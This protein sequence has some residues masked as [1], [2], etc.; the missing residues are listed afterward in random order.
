MLLDYL[1]RV[2]HSAASGMAHPDSGHQEYRSCSSF[3]NSAARRKSSEVAST[4]VELFL[5]LFF[6]RFLV[7]T[8]TSFAYSLPHGDPYH[9]NCALKARP[10]FGVSG[11]AQCARRLPTVLHNCA[12]KIKSQFDIAWCMPCG[13]RHAS[14]QGSRG[15]ASRRA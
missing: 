13:M 6:L 2:G 4:I 5:F 14:D 8:S 7:A 3:I 1:V 9:D 12:L 10:R 11:D 15:R